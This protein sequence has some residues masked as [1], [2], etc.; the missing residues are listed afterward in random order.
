MIIPVEKKVRS[1]IAIPVPSERIEALEQSVKHLDEEIGRH[2]RWVRP[3]GIHLTLKFMGD[4]PA[5]T[6]ERVLEALLPVTA[7]FN[8]FQLSISGLGVFPN[9]RRPRVLWAGLDGGLKSLSELH[10]AVDEAV[11]KL[12]LPKDQRPFSPHL[13][14]GRVRRDAAEGQ[15]QKIGEAMSST[16]IPSVPAWLADTVNLMRTELDPAG[17]R[18]YLMGSAPIGGG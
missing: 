18:H 12:G 14:L 6:A 7:G 17:S 2:V 8:S 13:T 9:S 11:E 1:F 5:A 4:I 3:E 15:L 16:K 10:M